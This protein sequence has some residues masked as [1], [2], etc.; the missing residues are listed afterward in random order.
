MTPV[1][2]VS[3][4]AATQRSR[5]GDGG[6]AGWRR[7]R[8]RPR[9]R[10]DRAGRRIGRDRAGL[11]RPQPTDDSVGG[12]VDL[13]GERWPV[14]G[15]AEL[16]KSRRNVVGLA[17]GLLERREQIVVVLP[18]A[19]ACAQPTVAQMA[20]TTGRLVRRRLASDAAADRRG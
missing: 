11:R 12:D 4:E 19:H 17:Q 9:C 7:S 14:Y 1:E 3:P 15:S 18:N 2:T 16:D 10:D 13:E 8:C 20:M 6:T 5:N